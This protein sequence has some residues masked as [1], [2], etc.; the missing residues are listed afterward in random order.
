MYSWFR[1]TKETIH[2]ITYC[3]L[4]N[5]WKALPYNQSAN[6]TVLWLAP[7]SGWLSHV[8]RDL[9][10]ICEKCS[11]K[12]A[13]FSTPATRSHPR[14]VPSTKLPGT[15]LIWASLWMQWHVY[16]YVYSPSHM[17]LSG[18]VTHFS[19]GISATPLH[20]PALGGKDGLRV[21]LGNIY[22]PPK[23]PGQQ[24]GARELFCPPVFPAGCWGALQIW[25][26]FYKLDQAQH[27]SILCPSPAPLRQHTL[28]RDAG[29]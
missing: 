2:Y 8:L 9:Q 22:L 25:P 29:S 10:Q 19:W 1:E 12:L 28:G 7:N 6:P 26:S 23:L 13:S 21:A 14:L 16:I 18:D 17:A 15:R 11:F 4:L 3:L 20:L 5:S 24:L 27:S